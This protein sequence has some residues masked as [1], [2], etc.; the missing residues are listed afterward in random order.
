MPW[1]SFSVYW[2]ERG[3]ENG[4]MTSLSDENEARRYARLI[5]RE[6]KLRSDYRPGE[7]KMVVRDDNGAVI[8]TITF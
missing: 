6:L 4:R 5:I 3:L 2:P 7:Q 1:Y 8:E